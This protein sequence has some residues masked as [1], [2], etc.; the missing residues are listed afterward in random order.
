MMSDVPRRMTYSQHP[1]SSRCVHNSFPSCERNCATEQRPCHTHTHT[2]THRSLRQA[3]MEVARCYVIVSDRQG[4][5]QR[6]KAHMQ[7]RHMCFLMRWY[8]WCLLL[9]ASLNCYY[10]N[11]DVPLEEWMLL[12][13]FI[14]RFRRLRGRWK[15]QYAVQCDVSVTL[16]SH[17]VSVVNVV[18][19]QA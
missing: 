8:L 5:C 15:C 1:F 19:T 12:L 9:P 16:V 13:L 17:M 7:I 18:K 14:L 11:E 6:V 2:H 10:I 3:F 4:I